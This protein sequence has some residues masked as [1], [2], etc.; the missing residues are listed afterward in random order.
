VLTVVVLRS[1]SHETLAPRGS[2]GSSISFDI[3]ALEGVANRGLIAA[4]Q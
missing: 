2:S 4:G 3:V 1:R